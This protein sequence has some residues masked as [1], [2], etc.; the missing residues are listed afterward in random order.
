MGLLFYGEEKNEG[1]VGTSESRHECCGSTEQW[2]GIGE[3]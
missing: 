1:R 2:C 3:Q